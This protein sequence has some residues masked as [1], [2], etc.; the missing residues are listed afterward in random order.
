[1][2][3]DIRM[4]LQRLAKVRSLS[5]RHVFTFRGKPIQRISRFFRTTV[6]DAGITDF[7]FHDLRHC[8]STNLRRAG[9]DTA[10]AM[11]I[12]GHKSEKMWKRYNAIEERDL[13][14]AALKVQKYLQQN[15]PGTLDPKTES[16]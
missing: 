7:R 2:T 6:K 11:K 12:V 1:M 16:L 9:V 5:T 13:V 14:Q 8:A 15:T 4:T 10:T 3:P